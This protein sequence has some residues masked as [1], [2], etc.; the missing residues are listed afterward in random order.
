[1]IHSGTFPNPSNEDTEQPPQSA[2]A[3]ATLSGYVAT[4]SIVP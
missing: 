4:K 1:M 2:I 3:A